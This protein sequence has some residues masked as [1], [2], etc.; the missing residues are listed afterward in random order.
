MK[1][2][3]ALSCPGPEESRYE[4]SKKPPLYNGF[5]HWSFLQEDLGRRPAY[6]YF[7]TR[8]LPGDGAGAFH[9]AE[10]WYEFGT[11]GRSWRP[12]GPADD[13]LSEEMVSFF[14]NFVIRGD[15]NGEGVPAWPAC[16]RA[17]PHVHVF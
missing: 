17:E 9:S 7:F 15:P 12:M 1:I 3:C 6:V 5:L 14:T 4:H 16:R 11:L 2:T 13:V 8:K 10:L